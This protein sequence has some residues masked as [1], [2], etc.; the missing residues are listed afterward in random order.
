MAGLAQIHSF[1]YVGIFTHAL[2]KYSHSP[3]PWCWLYLLFSA[4]LSRVCQTGPLQHRSCTRMRCCH[5]L[6]GPSTTDRLFWMY[7]VHHVCVWCVYD[8]CTMRE[9][10]MANR[11]ALHE[12]FVNNAVGAMRECLLNA[13]RLMCDCCVNNMCVV[14]RMWE[15][16]VKVVWLQTVCFWCLT[17]EPEQ[18]ALAVHTT[19][20]WCCVSAQAACC[21]LQ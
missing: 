18:A 13:V 14:M 8:V 15:R 20:K 19:W 7:C 9:R 6:L 3:V 4:F 21:V 10:S 12:L 17:H 5:Y 2:H 16:R 11:C 1:C